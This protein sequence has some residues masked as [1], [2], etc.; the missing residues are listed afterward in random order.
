MRARAHLSSRWMFRLETE[1]G[2]KNLAAQS[3]AASVEFPIN[4]GSRRAAIVAH[5][6][7]DHN[8]QGTKPPAALTPTL[9]T[10]MPMRVSSRN[11]ARRSG[12]HRPRQSAEVPVIRTERVDV[13]GFS[14]YRRLFNRA[15]RLEIT[16]TTP[17]HMGSGC[18][19]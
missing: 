14:F 8:L 2:L 9:L 5:R 11:R 3:L 17:S 4:Q 12:P 18:H 16:I 19:L 6:V 7:R 10:T 1:K 13:I 15:G